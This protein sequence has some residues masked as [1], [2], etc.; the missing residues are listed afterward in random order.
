M[1]KFFV[2]TS[3]GWLMSSAETSTAAYASCNKLKRDKKLDYKVV[4][5][6]PY[7]LILGNPVELSI[8]ADANIV[9]DGGVAYSYVSESYYNT[10]IMERVETWTCPY[11]KAEGTF[12]KNWLDEWEK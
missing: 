2:T 10:H 7:R 1:N 11:T 8:P 12:D 6:T 3:R 9:I 5:A 4:R